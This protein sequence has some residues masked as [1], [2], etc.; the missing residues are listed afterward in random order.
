MGWLEKQGIMLRFLELLQFVN[1]GSGIHPA[2][3]SMSAK[4][5]SAEGKAA[6]M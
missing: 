2:F 1:I 3:F 6:M 5:F 4:G